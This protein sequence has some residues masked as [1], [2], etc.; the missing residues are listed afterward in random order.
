MEIQ[1][2]LNK[3][4]NINPISDNN[5]NINNISKNISKNISNDS[6]DDSEIN[7]L[8]YYD[9]QEVAISLASIRMFYKQRDFGYMFKPSITLSEPQE[10]S[11]LNVSPEKENSIIT[12]KKK[13]NNNIIKSKNNVVKVP[14]IPSNSKSSKSSPRK[15]TVYQHEKI[16][17][18]IETTKNNVQSSEISRFFNEWIDEK[19]LR[20]PTYMQDNNKNNL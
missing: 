17:Q 1:K 12:Q 15:V 2:I 3:G 11:M 10:S 13:N 8:S 7:G 4:N 9:A 19:G 5:I 20:T 18:K 6:T 16:N 14:S